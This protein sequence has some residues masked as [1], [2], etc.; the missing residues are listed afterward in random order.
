M[1]LMTM[2][3]PFVVLSEMSQQQLDEICHEM[4][5]G[6]DIHVPLRMNCNNFGDPSTFHLAPP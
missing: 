6:S 4:K 3:F 2:R 5:F 1:S